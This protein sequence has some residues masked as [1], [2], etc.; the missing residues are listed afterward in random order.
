MK[1]YEMMAQVTQLDQDE[2]LNKVSSYIDEYQQKGL[3]IEIQYQFNNAISSALILGYEEVT[4][5]TK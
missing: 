3:Q 2:F 5:G 1:K 4:D